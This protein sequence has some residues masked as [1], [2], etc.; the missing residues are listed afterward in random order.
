M[1]TIPIIK[2]R[3]SP[4]C[5]RYGVKKA[6]L[7]GSYSRGEAHEASDVDL[8]IERGD[9]DDLFTMIG[10]RLDLKDALQKEVDLISILPESGSFRENLKRDEVLLYE[11]Q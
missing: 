10:F 1:L 6:Y 11:T 2:Q 5:K 4:I 3:I 7:F 9:I 8:R